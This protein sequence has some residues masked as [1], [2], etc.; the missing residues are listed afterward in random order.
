MNN[1]EENSRRRKSDT[2]VP[3]SLIATILTVI[4]AMFGI[5]SKINEITEKEFHKN[6]TIY[7]R[8]TKIETKLDIHLKDRNENN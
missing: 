3:L 1:N 2:Y 6:Q 7:D 4:S 5:Y 8:L